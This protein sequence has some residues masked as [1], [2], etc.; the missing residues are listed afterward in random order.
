MWEQ[1][2]HDTLQRYRERWRQHGYDP[3]TLGWNKDCQWVRFHAALEGLSTEDFESVIDFGCGFGDFLGFLRAKHWNGRYTGIDVVDE[4]IGEARRIHSEDTQAT[5]VC[6]DMEHFSSS[7]KASM[8]LALGVFNHRLHQHNFEFVRQTIRSMWEAT[9]HVVVCD[10]LSSFAEASRRRSDL[11]YADPR[12]VYE[13]ASAYS[14][15]ISIGHA[16]MPFEFQV[17]IWHDDSFA[18]AAPVFRPYSHLAHEQTKRTHG[19][20]PPE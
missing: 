2:R 18:D 7:Q 12:E 6:S 5:F 10:F 16:Y 1:D 17:K 4:L 3:K 14:R 15:R 8:G 13:L 11:F 9:T 20:G 19:N